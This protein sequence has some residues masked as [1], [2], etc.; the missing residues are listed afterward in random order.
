VAVISTILVPRDAQGRP[1]SGIPESSLFGPLTGTS[2]ATPVVAGALA[3]L[4]QRRQSQGASL[5]PVAVVDELLQ[6][7]LAPLGLQPLISGKGRL[8]LQVL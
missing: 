3:L 8:D 6:N 4:F 7:G 2:V 1:I 5:E